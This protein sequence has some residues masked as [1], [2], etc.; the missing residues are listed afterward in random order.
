[1]YVKCMR[2][3]YINTSIINISVICSDI[4]R[5]SITIPSSANAS[6]G[7]FP[8]FVQFHPDYPPQLVGHA[9]VR[10]DGLRFIFIDTM[11]WKGYGSR[12]SRVVDL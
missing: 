6:V 11:S 1:M 9:L 2:R 4:F 3:R 5:L 7:L 8:G 12:S 10:H